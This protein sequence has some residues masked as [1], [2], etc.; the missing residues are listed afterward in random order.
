M[1]RFISVAIPHYNNTDFILE[2][3]VPLIE[4]LRINEIII[5][6]DKSKDINKLKNIL[7]HINSNK[8]KLFE[9]D[10]NLG[11]FNNKLEAVNKCNNE[12]CILLDSDNIYDK[13][14]IDKIFEIKEWNNN[15]IYTPSW[16]RTFPGIPSN[17]LNYKN[18]A[19]KIINKD[20]YL[21]E[22]NNLN[23]ECLINTCNYFLP[24]KNYRKCMKD[25]IKTYD[26]E[27]M[28]SL[29]SAIL[30]TEWLYKGYN[31]FTVTD[32]IYHHRLHKNSNYMLSGSKKYSNEIKMI[33]YNKIKNN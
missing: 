6:D 4:D 33:I 15:L 9:N 28:D 18:F 19:N 8:I 12:W 21:N 7:K 14:S 27:K 20:I 25:I 1:K 11:V 13:N 31:F 29:D 32:L 22:F 16:A 2:T 23:F 10:V 30:F 26:R 17:L 5:T 3:L 24:V